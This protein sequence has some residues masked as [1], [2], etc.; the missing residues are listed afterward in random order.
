MTQLALCLLEIGGQTIRIWF[1]EE[2]SSRWQKIPGFLQAQ[3]GDVYAI[4]R[5]SWGPQAQRTLVWVL[6]NGEV[7]KEVKYLM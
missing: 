6:S 1:Q 5:R 3:V 4:V 2:Y 7:D